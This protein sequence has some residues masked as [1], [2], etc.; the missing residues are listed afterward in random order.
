MR[1]IPLGWTIAGAVV[2]ALGWF[3]NLMTLGA[4]IN[5]VYVGHGWIT[6]GIVFCPWFVP[7]RNLW[8]VLVLNCI[9]YA[10]L[11][12]GARIAWSLF[13]GKKISN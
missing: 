1:N 8:V 10:S 5:G 7:V 6:L 4:I 2:G 9:L 13:H 3:Y 11:F 12:A